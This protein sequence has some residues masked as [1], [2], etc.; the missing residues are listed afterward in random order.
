VAVDRVGFDRER[1]IFLQ[2]VLAFIRDTQ[3]KKDARLDALTAAT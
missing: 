3:P 2:P 1:A